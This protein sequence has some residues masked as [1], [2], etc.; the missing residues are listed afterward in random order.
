MMDIDGPPS[1]VPHDE[2]QTHRPPRVRPLGRVLPDDRVFHGHQPA[3]VRE[4]V[5]VR[6]QEQTQRDSQSRHHH[7][8]GRQRARQRA[9]VGHRE[10]SWVG[11]KRP[12]RTRCPSGGRSAAGRPMTKIEIRNCNQEGWTRERAVGIGVPG[13]FGLDRRWRD[14][15]RSGFFYS[16]FVSRRDSRRTR[17]RKPRLPGRGEMGKIATMTATNNLGHGFERRYDS[18]TH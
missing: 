9:F 12:S 3:G 7:A 5:A 14:E 4:L 10:F 18:A 1:L 2:F 11:A 16:F 13:L 15:S 6:R 17:R 8:V